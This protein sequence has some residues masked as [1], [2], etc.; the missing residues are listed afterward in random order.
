MQNLEQV[1]EGQFFFD[2][3][4][5]I[6]A[7]HFPG[8][9]VVPGSLIIN[10]FI[11]AAQSAMRDVNACLVENFRFRRFISP[12]RYAFRL[13]RIGQDVIRCTLFDTAR[14]VVSGTLQES[15]QSA[16]PNTGRPGA[17]EFTSG[18]R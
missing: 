18:H 13:Q 4:D 7:D 11:T 1:H 6:Y 14:T 12:G 8:K 15:S 5:P 9:P 17:A 3:R 16:G 2:P 10:A